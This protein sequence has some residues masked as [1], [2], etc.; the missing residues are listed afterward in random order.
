[1]AAPLQSTIMAAD[2]LYMHLR[3]Q[4]HRIWLWYNALTFHA[5]N[6]LSAGQSPSYELM[7][8][9]PLF[10]L[11]YP[12]SPAPITRIENMLLGTGWFMRRDMVLWIA[13]LGVLS[14][15]PARSRRVPAIWLFRMANEMRLDNLCV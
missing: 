12:P 8:H 1:M 5:C 7:K 9:P 13:A 3:Q 10:C 2:G 6:P 15:V 4:S 14:R 11:T